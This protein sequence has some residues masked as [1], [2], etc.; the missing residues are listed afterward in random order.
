MSHY[1]T[2]TET[3]LFLN[4]EQFLAYAKSSGSGIDEHELKDLLTNGS[5]HDSDFNDGCHS[6]YHKELSMVLVEDE[7]GV[8]RDA[9]ELSETIELN[10][11]WEE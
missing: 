7:D 9:W 10:V 4:F 8:T 11:L 2:S 5:S 3:K 6:D 1:E